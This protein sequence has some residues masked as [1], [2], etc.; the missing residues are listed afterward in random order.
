MP[1]TTPVR[2]DRVAFDPRI[3]SSGLFDDVDD[4]LVDVRRV[5]PAVFRSNRS[6][7]A[8]AFFWAAAWALS[9][10]A[11]CFASSAA[12][13]CRSSSASAA[14]AAWLASSSFAVRISL[15]DSRSTG[16]PYRASSGDAAIAA[17]IAVSALGDMSPCGARSLVHAT[18][19]GAPFSFITVTTASPVPSEVRTSP[20]S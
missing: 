12:M 10:A 11:C 2:I 3:S 19:D 8:S 4:D 5:V 9:A 6:Y 7:S 17:S 16:V 20:S 18:G 15:A 1:S 13:R 14:S